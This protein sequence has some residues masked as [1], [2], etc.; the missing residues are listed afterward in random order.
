MTEKDPVRLLTMGRIAE[1]LGVTRVRV[2]YI[3]D[4]RVQIVPIAYAGKAGIYNEGAFEQIRDEL[5]K[6]DARRAAAGIVS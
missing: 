3:L 4:T 2:K 5:R 6:M 1:R